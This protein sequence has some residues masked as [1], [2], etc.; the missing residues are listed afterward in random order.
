MRHLKT[1]V[2]A[3]ALALGT[4]AFGQGAE[5]ALGGLRQDPGLPVEVTSDNL[6]VDQSD[7]SATFSGNV[8]VSQGEMRLTAGEVE[9]IYAP[10]GGRIAELRATGGVTLVAGEEAAESQEAVYTIDSGEV[11]MT[12]DVVLTQGANA[13]SSNRLTLDLTEGT[14]V[15]EGR[16]R[17]VFQTGGD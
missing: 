9:V 12:G 14:G 11:V 10:I 2:T 6:R 5:V 8:L 15:M 4:A 13:L 1:I 17:T 16:V 3:A 7:G